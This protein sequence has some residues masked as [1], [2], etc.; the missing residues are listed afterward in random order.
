MENKKY[1][2]VNYSDSDDD[3]NNNLLDNNRNA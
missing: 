1:K 2:V 3:D